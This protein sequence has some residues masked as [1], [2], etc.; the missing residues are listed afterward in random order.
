VFAGNCRA[1]HSLVGNESRH[2]QGGDLA[3]YRLTRQELV[4]FTREMPTPRP[5]T[6]AQLDVVVDYVLE[7]QRRGR[8]R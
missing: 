5:L 6:S 3:G 2:R 4:Q 7:F 8:A 1:C